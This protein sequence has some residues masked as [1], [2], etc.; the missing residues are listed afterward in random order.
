MSLRVPPQ[1][2]EA[3]FLFHV[4]KLRSCYAL[5]DEIAALSRFRRVGIETSRNDSRAQR[6]LLRAGDLLTHY[7]GG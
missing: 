2:D 7:E 6:D 1:R 4:A 5:T 3:I